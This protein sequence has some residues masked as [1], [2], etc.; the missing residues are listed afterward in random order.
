MAG[1]RARSTASGCCRTSAGPC[2]PQA[3]VWGASA[4]GIGPVG[5]VNGASG[6][7]AWP[8]GRE[9]LREVTAG[10]GV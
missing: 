7:G 4:V 5:H 10:A 6:L 1:Q 8:A 9:I 3:A 2:R